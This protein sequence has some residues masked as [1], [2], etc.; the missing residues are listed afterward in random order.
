VA[1][2]L[3]IG[4]KSVCARRDSVKS[5]V[6]AIVDARW[7][8]STMSL[9]CSGVGGRLRPFIT[10]AGG[11][12]SAPVGSRT[13]AIEK[14]KNANVCLEVYQDQTGSGASIRL[15]ARVQADRQKFY[16]HRRSTSSTEGSYRIQ[17]VRSGKYVAVSGGSN[18]IGA[19]IVQETW[20]GA[21]HQLWNLL[22]ISGQSFVLE[23]EKSGLWIN[24]RN[25]SSGTQVTQNGGGSA[26]NASQMWKLLPEP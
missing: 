10:F 11:R 6:G 23:N 4:D 17:A 24:D 20:S 13:S 3:S 1:T 15:A 26:Y 8:M 19:G 16:F 22:E 14:G 18:A 7:G 25:A 9:A 2:P 21:S 12:S 5:A